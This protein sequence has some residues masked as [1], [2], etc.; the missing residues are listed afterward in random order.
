[1]VAVWGPFWT[2]DIWED[3]EEHE[4]DEGD[5]PTEAERARGA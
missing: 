1:M 5:P 2:S 3:Q 4:A